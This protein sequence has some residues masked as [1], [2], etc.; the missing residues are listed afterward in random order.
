MDVCARLLRSRGHIAHLMFATDIY[1]AHVPLQAKRER[2]SAAE[3][4]KC[5]NVLMQQDLQ[6]LSI[7]C[8]VW[9]N[10]LQQPARAL[11]ERHL[12]EFAER[13]TRLGATRYVWRPM[14]YSKAQQDFV[15]RSLLSGGCP[16]C[17]TQASGGVCEACGGQFSCHELSEARLTRYDGSAAEPGELQ[18]KEQ[19]I[20]EFEP[21]A[22]DTKLLLE[23]ITSAAVDTRFRDIARED[24]V[25]RHARIELTTPGRWGVRWDAPCVEEHIIYNYCTIY[26]YALALGELWQQFSNSNYNAFD[27]NSKVTSIFSFGIDV[28]VCGITYPKAFALAD[29]DEQGKPRYKTFDLYWGNDFMQ[30]EGSKF[31]TSR[32][33]AIWASELIAKTPV[34]ADAVRYYLA[35]IDPGQAQSSFS[36][37]GLVEIANARVS[38]KII[39][40]AYHLYETVTGR[41]VR[42][43]GAHMRHAL[44]EHL[45][46]QQ[47]C[48]QAANLHMPELIANLDRWVD[49]QSSGLDDAD[50]YW[51]L[52]GLALLAYPLMPDF[53]ERLWLSLGHTGEPCIEHFWTPCTPTAV[54]FEPPVVL[55]VV[56]LKPCLPDTLSLETA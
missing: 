28:A 25:R 21:S 20:L 40:M 39:T 11:Y 17:G 51:Y 5:N 49:R 8:D 26:P 6:A 23:Q 35:T 52:K 47:Q 9:F 16:T 30:L 27:V 29:T 13:L 37:E 44:T 12:R 22:G 53:G 4:I 32:R 46:D 56:D 54:L 38:V 19:P 50:G 48:M 43:P 1:E 18:W 42:S 33:H 2:R 41:E 3:V 36:L 7:D 31:S 24:V 15:P 10:P 34:S 55:N 14:P 45:A